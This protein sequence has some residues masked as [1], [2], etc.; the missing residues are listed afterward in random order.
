MP[1][2]EPTTRILARCLEEF[3]EQGDAAIEAACARYPALSE[4]I[5]TAVRTLRELLAAA[6]AGEEAGPDLDWKGRE[7]LGRFLLGEKL[8]KGGMGVVYKALDP[9]L[10]REVAIKV[11]PAPVTHSR[12]ARERFRRE[13]EALAQVSHPHIV[14]IHEVGETEDGQ[15]YLVMPFIEGKTLAELLPELAGDVKTLARMLAEIAGAVDHAHRQGLVHRDVKPG[16]ILVDRLGQSCLIDFGVARNLQEAGVT[17]SGALLGTPAFMAPEQ[18]RD[19]AS[20]GPRTD[21]YALGATLYQCLTRKLPFEARSRDEAYDRICRRDPVSPRTIRPEV[22]KDLETICLTAMEKDP[23]RRYQ[24]AAE[25]EADLRRFLEYRPLRARPLGRLARS[26]RWVRRNRAVAAVILLAAL[27][28]VLGPSSYALYM[29]SLAAQERRAK[30][31][32]ARESAQ[33]ETARA[34]AAYRAGRLLAQRGR[35]AEALRHYAAAVEHHPDPVLVSI[36]RIE[37]LEGSLDAPAAI[38]ELESLRRR[39]VPE[40]YEAKLLLLEADLG[41]N[42]LLDPDAK[43]ELVDRALAMGTLEPADALLA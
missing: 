3:Q 17:A 10:K 5:R 27:V 30:E 38:R 34:E 22:P 15:P 33:K 37:A 2:P 21:V 43:M 14:P 42:R 9:E 11:F 28:V 25:L 39:K 36:G 7:R 16:N 35:W 24:S 41:V 6:G 32:I 8:G 4:R 18:I 40:K 26:A 12:E 19:P 13:A 29:G 20:V 1:D 23:A 31:S